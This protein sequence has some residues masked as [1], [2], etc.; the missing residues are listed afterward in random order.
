V[1]AGQDEIAPQEEGE[2]AIGD[3]NVQEEVI[4]QGEDEVLGEAIDA[5]ED[6]VPEITWFFSFIDR[7]QGTYLVGADAEDDVGLTHMRAS[8]QK[9][10]AGGNPLAAIQC[11]GKVTCL[12]RESVT[13]EPG[14]W[15]LSIQAFDTSGQASEPVIDM[16]EVIASQDGLPAVAD[17]EVSVLDADINANLE[18]MGAQNLGGGFGVQDLIG[19]VDPDQLSALLNE[20]PE[21]QEPLTAASLC[22]SM[23]IEQGSDGNQITATYTCEQGVESSAGNSLTIYLNRKLSNQNTLPPE[24]TN[25]AY[26]EVSSVQP[27]DTFSIL[28]EGFFCGANY[29]YGI[30]LLFEGDPYYFASGTIPNVQ[31]PP[32][33]TDSIGDLNLRAELVPEGTA[34]SWQ[35][36]ASPNW[37]DGDV[38]YEIWRHPLNQP[39]STLIME[40]QLSGAQ[41]KHNGKSFLETASLICDTNR[42][43]IYALIVMNENDEVIASASAEQAKPEECPNPIGNVQIV[44][45]AAYVSQLPWMM[46]AAGAVPRH[47]PV[48]YFQILAQPGIDW[49]RIDNLNLSINYLDGNDDF[50]QPF[51]NSITQIPI[52]Q[53]VRSNGF[54]LNTRFFVRCAKEYKIGVNLRSGDEIISNIGGYYPAPP[55]LPQ[56]EMV[57][58]FT[59]IIGLDEPAECEV[60]KNVG[61]DFCIQLHWEGAPPFQGDTAF[62]AQLPLSGITVKRITRSESP[63]FQPPDALIDLAREETSL[64]DFVPCVENGEQA[65]FD[66]YLIGRTQEGLY[67]DRSPSVAHINAPVCGEPYDETG[68]IR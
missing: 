16:F 2:V 18:Q 13:L 3:E 55:C 52:T 4:P 6:D 66:Y 26:P 22:L 56:A 30:Y 51:P 46:D 7:E 65:S 38:R 31:Q 62:G 64:I 11:N 19:D 44:P 10:G 17:H 32:C 29:D 45:N 54:N 47:F 9:E 63:S 53:A 33:A 48:I 50:I 42:E 24:G 20:P 14:V 1:G 39:F 59:S 15:M 34:L 57:P 58:N 12:L 40:E 37:P 36:P 61:E 67:G 25:K 49:P 68:E 60:I 35:F 21:E 8:L 43:Y 23:S 27:G 5:P 41:F 28:D